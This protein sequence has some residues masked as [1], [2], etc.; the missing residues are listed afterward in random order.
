MIRDNRSETA[1][2]I[3]KHKGLREDLMGRAHRERRRWR[4]SKSKQKRQK[5]SKPSEPWRLKTSDDNGSYATEG[6][7]KLLLSALRSWEVKR[8]L[9]EER[10]EARGW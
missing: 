5:S 10:R 1:T 3:T 2:R 7:D 9:I 6:I 8:D 4:M